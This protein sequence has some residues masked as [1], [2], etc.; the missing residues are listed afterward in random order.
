M[1]LSSRTLTD[2]IYAK[3]E[4]RFT[5]L[6]KPALDVTKKFIE[7]FADGF[8]QFMNEHISVQ[9]TIVIDQGGLQQYGATTTGAGGAPVT[10]LS[11]TSAPA[12]PVT[13]YGQ[14]KFS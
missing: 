13:I 10:T 6:P 2:Q 5:R 14:G 3:I 7:C 12:Q 8:I 1:A 11:P 4:A 9:V